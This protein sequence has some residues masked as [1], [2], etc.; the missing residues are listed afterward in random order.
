LHHLLKDRVLETYLTLN[1]SRF[2]DQAQERDHF[3]AM[4]L[5]MTLAVPGPG[6]GVPIKK[7]LKNLKGGA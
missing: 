4:L 3:D 5:A 6:Q 7:L 2:E 1:P